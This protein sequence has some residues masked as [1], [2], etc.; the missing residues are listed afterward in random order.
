LFIYVPSISKTLKFLTRNQQEKE[1]WMKIFEK[2]EASNR[3]D[4]ENQNRIDI[5]KENPV[6]IPDECFNE[7]CS[8][9]TEFTTFNRRHHCRA[10]G[11]IF[12]SKCSRNSIYLDYDD[13]DRKHRVCDNCY[14]QLKK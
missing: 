8:C 10:C 14:E 3:V 12:C 2:I 5:G 13:T 4:K 9:N 7:C 1:T 6:W 11:F